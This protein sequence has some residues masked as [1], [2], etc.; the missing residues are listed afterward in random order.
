MRIGVIIPS[1]NT[2][3]EGELREIFSSAV[4]LHFTRLALN[5]SSAKDLEQ[6]TDGL[7]SAISLLADAKVDIII[8]HCTAVSTFSDQMEIS[9][10]DRAKNISK[11]IPF[12]TTATAMV[13]MLKQ[14]HVQRIALVT[15]YIEEITRREITYLSARNISV[16]SHHSEGIAS[17]H[18]MAAVTSEYWA[19]KIVQHASPDLDGYLLSCNGIR[20]LNELEALEARLGKPVITSNTALAHYCFSE[21]ES[22]DVSCCIAQKINLP[23]SLLS[24]N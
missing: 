2:V 5:G 9:L 16:L 7:E 11:S 19:D 12:I 1:A 20:S 24:I 4:G 3:A 21:L 10:L 15:P 18:Q 22:T 14:L 23:K 8:F 6:M 13:H 17:P